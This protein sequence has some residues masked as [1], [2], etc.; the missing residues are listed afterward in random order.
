MIASRITKTQTSGTPVRS[1]VYP[2][3]WTWKTHPK[4]RPQLLVAA[5]IKGRGGRKLWL[6]ACLPSV[7]LASSCIWLLWLVLNPTSSE[8]QCRLKTSPSHCLAYCLEPVVL[9]LTSFPLSWLLPR[10]ALTTLSHSSEFF[11]GPGFSIWPH[12]S[13]LSFLRVQFTQGPR[14]SSHWL[15]RLLFKMPCLS[16]SGE[17]PG[18]RIFRV[19]FLPLPYPICLFSPFSLLLKM[20]ITER[21]VQTSWACLKLWLLLTSSWHSSPGV[22]SSP[23]ISLG[24]SG[25]S[26]LLWKLPH[27]TLLLELEMSRHRPSLQTAA[28]QRPLGVYSLESLAEGPCMSFVISWLLL[29]SLNES[30]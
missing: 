11:C 30:S 12:D 16:C 19:P 20:A 7:S 29:Y 23:I 5:H 25:L 10:S 28:N 6:F 3:I 8:F 13:W 2:I 22:G 1:F 14:L 24:H 4:L 26:L 21:Q 9:F 18:E 15:S 17:C 27:V